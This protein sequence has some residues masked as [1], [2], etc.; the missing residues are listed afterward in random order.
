MGAP[1]I[2][3]ILG[4][5]ALLALIFATAF[6]WYRRRNRKEPVDRTGRATW[7]MPP[8]DR[9]E[10]ARM[11]PLARIWMIVLRGYLLLAGG[12]VL[13]RILELAT[14]AG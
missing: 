11:T 1:T 4:G 12:L 10:R 13:A 5:G 7:R 2:V 6:F 8:L 9:L 14:S 3:A